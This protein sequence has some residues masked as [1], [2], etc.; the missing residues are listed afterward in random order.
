MIDLIN[1]VLNNE[2]VLKLLFS[3]F[4]FVSFIFFFSAFGYRLISNDIKP[5]DLKVLSRRVSI[6]A[7]CLL[8]CLFLV[9]Y[10]IYQ[11]YL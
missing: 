3:F 4:M 11:H 9:S 7:F 2:N 6:S 8:V 5:T 1:D 10:Y